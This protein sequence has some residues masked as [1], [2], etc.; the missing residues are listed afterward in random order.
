[1]KTDVVIA[2]VGTACGTGR[3]N[4]A[5]CY[6]QEKGNPAFVKKKSKKLAK[7]DQR[8][9]YFYCQIREFSPSGAACICFA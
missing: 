8:V 9:S 1:M 3:Q 2:L 5:I 6:M 4:I 7:S